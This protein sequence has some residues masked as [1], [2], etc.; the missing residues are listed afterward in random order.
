MSL[1]LTSAHA[2]RVAPPAPGPPRGPYEVIAATLKAQI[3][4]GRPA[5]GDLGRR[6][7]E[8]LIVGG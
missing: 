4:D 7:R 1:P 5:P 2:T 3:Q 6:R 8:L